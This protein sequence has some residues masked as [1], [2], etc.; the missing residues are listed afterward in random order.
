MEW[1]I[2]GIIIKSSVYKESDA[3]LTCFSRE[4]G[5]VSFKARGVLKVT[6]KNSSA[7]QLYTIGE[8]HLTSKNEYG[9]KTLTGVD[10]IKYP[11][12]LFDNGKYLALL[13][14]LSE[15]ILKLE[16]E[17]NN[18]IE[19]YDVFIFLLNNIS[20]NYSLIF[21]SLI[22]FK[23]LFDY[24]GLHLQVD[25]CCKCSNKKNIVGI[26]YVDGGFICGKCANESAGFKEYPAEYLRIFRYIQKAKIENVFALDIDTRI[27]YSI[28]NTWFNY[29]YEAIGVNFKS[30]DILLENC[31]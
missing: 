29:L 1:T 26:S 15:A 19:I 16:L 13:A 9:H 2:K 5:L 23:Y 8:Y 21:A 11:S 6:S 27:G 12:S 10:V 7:C 24:S 14:F 25:E 3:I 20:K 30:K 4:Y 17:D 22:V 31:K 28:L 18:L